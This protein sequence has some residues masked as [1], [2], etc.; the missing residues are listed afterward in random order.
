MG[1]IITP[2]G[3]DKIYD[4][5]KQAKQEALKAAV[6]GRVYVVAKVVGMTKSNP[7]FVK[8]KDPKPPDIDTNIPISAKCD[9]DG[10]P[11]V[12]SKKSSTGDPIFL[13]LDCLGAKNDSE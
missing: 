13:C 9:F 12:A 8:H 3:H 10:K 11:A 7:T 2:I 1:Y 5:V 4:S 6:D